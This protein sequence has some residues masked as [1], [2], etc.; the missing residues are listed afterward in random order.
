MTVPNIRFGPLDLVGV[1]PYVMLVL[2]LG[3]LLVLVAALT[4]VERVV[5]GL[6]HDRLGPNRV[7]PRGVL[8]PIA[9]GVKLFFKEEVMP[10]GVNRAMYQLAPVLTLAPPL[11]VIALIPVG[12][13]KVDMGGGETRRL[14]LVVADMNVGILWI[15]ALASLQVYG[16]VLGGWASNNKYSL[17]GGLRASAQAISYELAMT[18]AILSVVLMTGSL[19]LVGITDGQSGGVLHWSIL[20]WFPLG[21]VACLVY[22]VAIAAESNRVPFDLPEAESELV[23]GYQTEYSAMKFAIYFMGEYAS[24]V[25]LSCVATVLW[26]GGWYAPLPALD[27]IPGPVWFFI[28]VSLLIFGFIWVRAT[29][30]RIRYDALMRFGWKRL[31]PVALAVLML[32]AVVEAYRTNPST[33][34]RIPLKPE[35]PSPTSSG[36]QRSSVQG[37]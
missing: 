2:M 23:A 13:L 31:F 33:P 37:R 14:A 36:P 3:I 25:I 24:I 17:L 22:M 20:R 35:K 30:P 5:L 10:R 15:L 34:S 11:A 9:D 12:Y 6:I 21:L 19:S 7:G 18:T 28:K 4:W 32:G 29:L 16:L 8:Q 27:V 26:F 1:T